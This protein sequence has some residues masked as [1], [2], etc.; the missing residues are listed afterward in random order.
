MNADKTSP[1]ALQLKTFIYLTAGIA[2]LAGLLFGYDTGVISGAILFIK[3]QFQLTSARIERV[4]SAV[5]LGAVIGAAFSGALTDRFGRR[6]VIIVT[7]FLFAIGAIGSAFAINVMMLILFRIM[8]G[9]AIGVASYAAPLYIS[10]ISPPNVRGALVSLNQLMITCGIVVSYLIDYALSLGTNEWRWMLGLGAVPAIILII[11]MLAL[12]ESPRWLVSRNRVDEARSVLGRMMPGE[13]VDREI[14]TIN[15]SLV[16]K[17]GSWKEILE[18]WIRPALVVGI[19]L[20]FFQQVT[21]INTIIYY[22]PTIFEFAGFESHKVSI[23]ATVGVGVVNVLMTVVAIWFIDRIGRKPL[24]YIGMAGMALSLGVVGF[25]F[26]SPN[27]SGAVKII[28]MISVMFYIA[29][30]A[31]SLGPIFWLMIAEIYPLKIRGRAMSL[32]TVA[33]WGF[34]MIVASTFLTL[35]EKLGKAG[36]FWFYAVVCVIGM[37]FCFFYVPETK[38]HTLEEIEDHLKSSKS[39]SK[40]GK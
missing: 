15:R 36:A 23:L 38:G 22:A 30:F 16:I 24:L 12:S 27:L 40:L 5:L 6:K 21:G 9:I 33:N 13:D 10:E 29:S 35:I 37:V 31:I 3:D 1:A 32:A 14:D 8:I 11:G 19:G 4:V 34:N 18:P 17:Q 28:T 25:A 7:A 20:A 26:Y 2:A 39:F